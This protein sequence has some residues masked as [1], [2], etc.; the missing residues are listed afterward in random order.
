MLEQDLGQ[1]PTILLNDLNFHVLKA[2]IEFMYCG[3]TSISKDNL[4]ALLMA[5]QV[6]K[7]ILKKTSFLNF[8]SFF[9]TVS[10][11]FLTVLNI[12]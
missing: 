1:E 3:E 10:Y 5:A 4:E 12:F 7:V 2:M 11:I 9:L 8:F 6:F